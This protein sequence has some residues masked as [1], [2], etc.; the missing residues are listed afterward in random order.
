MEGSANRHLLPTSPTRNS[1]LDRLRVR[2]QQQTQKQQKEEE[3]A[4]DGTDA[5]T[6]AALVAATLSGP[7]V[8][9]RAEP[10]PAPLDLGSLHSVRAFAGAYQRSGRPLHVLVRGR[11][12]GIVCVA[13][14]WRFFRANH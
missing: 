1:R 12:S 11:I 10:A 4:T 6:T 8:I 5:A 2:Q 9:G 13:L 7:P 3:E 14:G